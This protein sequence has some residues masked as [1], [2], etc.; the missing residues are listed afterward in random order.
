MG[1]DHVL[2]RALPASTT[3]EAAAKER[4]LDRIAEMSTD[5]LYRLREF[6]IDR[7]PGLEGALRFGCRNLLAC[8]NEELARRG[9]A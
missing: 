3:T 5:E 7:L 9:A 2:G 1:V 6:A 4:I 8:A